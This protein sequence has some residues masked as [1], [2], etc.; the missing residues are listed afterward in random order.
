MTGMFN[1]LHM[2]LGNI[3]KLSSAQTR[4]ITAENVYGEK[5]RG[6]MAEVSA[7]PQ[8]AVSQIGQQWDG[9]N[10]AARDLGQ[11]WLDF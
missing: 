11:F 4:S 1:G 5:G 8:P 6:G 3:A 2:G 7:T 9:P 10:S